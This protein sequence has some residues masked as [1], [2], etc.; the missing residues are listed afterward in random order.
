MLTPDEKKRVSIDEAIYLSEDRFNEP[1]EI[2]KKICSIIDKHNYSESM[3]VCDIGCATGEFLY[4][5]KKIFPKS[6]VTGFDKSNSMIQL[7]KK[8]IPDGTFYEGDANSEQFLPKNSFDVITMTGV[9]SIFDD[10]TP[11]IKNSILS[12]KK[13]GSVLISGSFNPNPIDVILKYRDATST[14]TSLKSGWNVHSCHSIERIIQ[15]I[16][17]NAKFSW[18][19]FEMPFE[20]KQTSDFMRTWTVKID[21][22]TSLVNGASQ[23]VNMKI[24]E[25]NI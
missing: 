18:H 3:S 16:S 22:K 1:K 12:L 7:A 17:P 14:D 5:L 6:S 24:L 8:M 10:P 25:I 2:F 21:G 15:K 11:S 9:L 19:D 23:I 20:I 13:D 4:H